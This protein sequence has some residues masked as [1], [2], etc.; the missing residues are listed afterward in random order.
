MRGP[1]SAIDAVAQ[2]ILR[3]HQR[4][5]CDPRMFCEFRM[6]VIPTPLRQIRRRRRG[7][8]RQQVTK[9]AILARVRPIKKC[10]HFFLQFIR[11]LPGIEFVESA[12]SHANMISNRGA[13]TRHVAPCTPHPALRTLHFAPVTRHQHPALS[14]KHQTPCCYTASAHDRVIAVLNKHKGL[15]GYKGYEEY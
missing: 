12:S 2:M 13:G 1:E 7:G 6:P 11:E 4:R 15:K 10:V 14:T 3:L 8:C 5:F 9:S